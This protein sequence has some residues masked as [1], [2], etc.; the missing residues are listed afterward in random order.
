MKDKWVD[1]GY[2]W[3]FARCILQTVKELHR[4]LGAMDVAEDGFVSLDD[5]LCNCYTFFAIIFGKLLDKKLQLGNALLQDVMVVLLEEV[6]KLSEVLLEYLLA[7]IKELD[8][9]WRDRSEPLDNEL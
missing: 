4:D 8:L 5:L 2:F 1:F 3:P 6:R 9:K 7:R